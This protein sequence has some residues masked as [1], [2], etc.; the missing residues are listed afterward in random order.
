M[1]Q[2]N[3][4]F[5]VEIAGI[6]IEICCWYPETKAYMN[7]FLSEKKPFFTV[8]P[9]EEEFETLRNWTEELVS[10]GYEEYQFSAISQESILIHSKVSEE[11]LNYD[12]LLVH[13]SAICMDGEVYLHRIE[14]AGEISV[15]QIAVDVFQVVR[16]FHGRLF[17]GEPFLRPLDILGTRFGNMTELQA[18]R[19]GV[20]RLSFH[21]A[22]F[23]HKVAVVTDAILVD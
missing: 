23:H 2:A 17:F 5:T 12:V 6:P 14:G 8:E 1:K 3:I 10:R 19:D 21:L 11:L 9:T 13:G 4:K 7:D 20:N 16:V 18:L 15:Q 22:V